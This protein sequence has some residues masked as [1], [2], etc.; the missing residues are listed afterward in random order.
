MPC[1]KCFTAKATKAHKGHTGFIEPM[2]MLGAA[3]S[4]LSRFFFRIRLV[5]VV[6]RDVQI[7]RF[8]FFSENLI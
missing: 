2:P 4:G 3:F 8:G 1:N 7:I 6:R 5:F